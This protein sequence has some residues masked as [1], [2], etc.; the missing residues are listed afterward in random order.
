MLHGTFIFVKMCEVIE[1]CPCKD[2]QRKNTDD[3]SI[4]TIGPSPV[5]SFA[6]LCFGQA[7]SVLLAQQTRRSGIGAEISLQILQRGA[8]HNGLF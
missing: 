6:S 5:R 1:F 3:E 7:R 2:M 4:S 8:K